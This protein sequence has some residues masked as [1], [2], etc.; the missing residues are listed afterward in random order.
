MMRKTMIVVSLITCVCTLFAGGFALTGVGSR[1][2]SMGGA[3]R[4]MADDGSAMYW[5]PAGL[6]FLDF[7]S[8]DLGATLILPSSKW[9]NNGTM[10]TG[11]TVIAGY[12]HKEYESKSILRGFPSASVVMA[13]NPKYK[14][15]LGIFVPY[16]LG[17]TW[18][19]YQSPTSMQMGSVTLPVSYESGFPKE[20]LMSSL[21]IVDIHPTF[22][23]QINS[24]L[25]AGLGMSIFY[26][27]I[28]LKTIDFKPNPAAPTDQSYQFAPITTDLQGEGLGFGFNFGLLYKATDLISLGISGKTPST[29][30]LEGDAEVLLWVPQVA[31]QASAKLGGKS[32]ITADLNLPGDIGVGISYK[33]KPNWVVNLDYAYTMWETLETVKVKM[34]DPIVITP[35]LSVSESQINF[36]W[37]DTHRISVGT[38]LALEQNSYRCGFFWDQSPIPEDTFSPTFPDINNKISSNFGFGHHFGNWTL[39]MNLQYIIF[40]EREIK[41]QNYTNNN[42]NGVYNANSISGNIGLT[43][44]L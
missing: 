11:E 34:D 2:T 19:A 8:Y 43:V 10:T 17:A 32:D 27:T 33:V 1:A 6:G 18:D 23:Y 21:A 26:S 13:K 30:S 14:F 3:V 15:G 25:S 36:L 24:D 4:G 5:N 12:E 7:N 16:G 44:K 41:T 31:T 35:A 20:E 40:S 37:E 39:D 9:D 38:E 22:A 42:K 28:Q 29:V